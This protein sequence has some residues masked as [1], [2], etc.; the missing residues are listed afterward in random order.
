MCSPPLMIDG[1]IE[2]EEKATRYALH[3]LRCMVMSGALL[4]GREPR[5]CRERERDSGRR[6]GG[7]KFSLR[8][9]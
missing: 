9:V 5:R 1:A 2:I 8:T 4:L 3:R 6:G 7:M